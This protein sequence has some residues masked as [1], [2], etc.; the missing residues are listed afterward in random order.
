[1]TRTSAQGN[2]RGLSRLKQQL[3]L[4]HLISSLSSAFRLSADVVLHELE[5]SSAAGLLSNI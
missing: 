5:E 2:I 4:S 3:G 1:L